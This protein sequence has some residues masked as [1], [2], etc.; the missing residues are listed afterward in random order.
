[1]GQEMITPFTLSRAVREW[2]FIQTPLLDLSTFKSEVKARGLDVLDQF[3]PAAWE[4]LD[5]EGMLEPV[6]YALTNDWRYGLQET[7]AAGHIRIREETGYVSWA[8]LEEQVPSQFRQPGSLHVLYHRWQILSLGEIQTALTPGVPWRE[9]AGG[10][11][12][13]YEQR[14]KFAAPPQPARSDQLAEI[15]SDGRARELLL[16]R[17]Q[18]M[19]WPAQWGG[20]G[21]ARYLSDAVN[22][23]TYDAH[24]LAREQLHDADYARLAAECDVNRDRLAEIYNNL[25]WHAQRIDP[26]AQIVELL[27]QLKRTKREKLTGRARLA[28]DWYDAARILRAWHHLIDPEQEP[29]PDIDE[30]GGASTPFKL[31]RF[32]TVDTDGNRGVL[33]AL[34]DD[35]GLYPWRVQLICEG[36]SEIQALET[37]VQEGYGLSFEHLGI[38]AT[39]MKGA[40]IPRGAERLLGEMHRYVNFFLMVFDNEGRAKEVIE[41]LQTA[42]TIEG[43]GEQR[44]QDFEQQLSAAV[45][46]ISNP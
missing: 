9:L 13:F 40:G 35:Y 6:A 28:V 38:V 33:P 32:E 5:R 23:L 44:R 7:L 2:C 36:K 34:L 25:V 10:L 41:A 12:S 20:P 31:Q 46:Q 26:N 3:N 18:N 1:M 43:I 16:V 27:S 17:V 29:L 21:H 19:L 8:E 4:T 14:A 42:G 11:K 15:A 39:D 22:G 37:I 24:D 45:E 30:H